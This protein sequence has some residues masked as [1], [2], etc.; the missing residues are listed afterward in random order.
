MHDPDAPSGITCAGP[1]VVRGWPLRWL[2]PPAHGP[3]SG[4][5]PPLP[6]GARLGSLCPP[7]VDPPAPPASAERRPATCRICAQ[8]VAAPN[9]TDSS[10]AA[11]A[12][13]SRRRS[14]A[15]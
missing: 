13:A 4:Y 2:A 15:D 10:V 5:L 7:R 1:G 14:L 12:S 6:A 3:T 8:T 9:T 11:P